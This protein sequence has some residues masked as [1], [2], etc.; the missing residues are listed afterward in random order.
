MSRQQ[1]GKGTK[2]AKASFSRGI[3][4]VR[5][6][7]L[8]GRYSEAEMIAQLKGLALD[9]CRPQFAQDNIQ[10]LWNQILRLRKVMVLEDSEIPWVSSL[11]F[12]CSPLLHD[13]GIL[14]HLRLFHCVIQ[15]ELV[16]M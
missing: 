13:L 8:F 9:P 3:E 7:S 15:L 2:N 5:R 10:P 12:T 6:N 11:T 1:G 16:F 4:D 14:L